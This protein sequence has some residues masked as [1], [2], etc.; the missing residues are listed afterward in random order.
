MDAQ[1]REEAFL[2]TVTLTERYLELQSELKDHLKAGY[3]G[4]A[5]ARYSLGATKV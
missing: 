5:Q 4:L 2:H 3:F 1:A